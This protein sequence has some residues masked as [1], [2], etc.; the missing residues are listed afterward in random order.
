MDDVQSLASYLGPLYSVTNI[1]GEPVV[2]RKLPNGFEFEVS[3]A[4]RRNGPFD[5]YVWNESRQIV[6]I[7]TRVHGRET[8]ADVMGYYSVRYQNLTDRY[9]VERE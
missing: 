7:Y 2:Y 4:S 8:L 9:R 1:D 5:L 3:G 6:G